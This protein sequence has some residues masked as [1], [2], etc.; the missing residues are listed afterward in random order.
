MKA[1]REKEHFTYKGELTEGHTAD[2]SA[3]TFQARKKSNNT[4]KVLTEGEKAKSLSTNN[5]IFSKAIT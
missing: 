5:M 2:F 3:E 1:V 4:F